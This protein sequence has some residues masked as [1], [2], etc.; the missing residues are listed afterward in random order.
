MNKVVSNN[1]L[2][3]IEW[4]RAICCIL[5]IIIHVT[6]EFWTSFSKGSIQYKF[7]ILLNTISQF[8]VP[9]FIFIS[10]FV[11][12]YVYHNRE[13][14][15]LDFYKKRMFKI[16]I[17]YLVWSSIYIIT[18]YVYYNISINL[19]DIAKDILIGRAS[20]HLYFMVLIIQFYLVFPLCLKIYQ[21]INNRTL[22]MGIFFTVNAIVILFIKMPFKDRFFMNYLMF[23]G[24]GFI[25]ADLKVNGFIPS[26]ALKTGIFSVYLIIIFYHLSDTYR[27]IAQLPLILKGL[28]R[29]SWW[30]FSLISIVNIYSLANIF[31]IRK[32][33]WIDNRAI[34]SLSKHSF[35]IYLSHMFFITVL[36]QLKGFNQL[37]NYSMTL[38]FVSELII[39][40]FIS[41]IAS[42]VLEK[43]KVMAN[44][45]ILK[46]Y[47]KETSI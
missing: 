45:Y 26:K 44:S 29:Y 10:G 35:T 39:I 34:S 31:K 33:N 43:L 8:A 21:K 47:Y 3:E 42:I 28:Y 5:V 46:K 11:L 23:F 18:R 13:Y 22:S 6:A 25:L 38:A 41:W 20:S 17:P 14:K 1:K 30:I 15:A 9:C 4:I 40:I 37:K 36:R 16:V 2:G 24:L 7:I 12:Y 27:N 32:Y 19:K